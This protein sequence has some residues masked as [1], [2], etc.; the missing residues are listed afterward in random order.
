MFK[1]T[2]DEFIEELR[3]EIAGYDEI[4]EEKE[5]DFVKRIEK[6]IDAEKGKNKRISI[7]TNSIIIQLEDETDLF[8]I[9]DQ[10]LVSILDNEEDLYW[11]NWKL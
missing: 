10:Y 5:E 4:T 3:A 11:A 7:E 6:Y 2:K 8:E 1:L 9:V